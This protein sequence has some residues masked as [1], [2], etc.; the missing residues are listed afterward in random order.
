MCVCGKYQDISQAPYSPP[1]G[2]LVEVAFSPSPPTLALT[3][4][5]T[6]ACSQGGIGPIATAI[7]AA[8]AAIS[9][10]L[11]RL[12]SRSLPMVCE[13]RECVPQEHP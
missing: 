12:L 2:S 8:A 11:P 5:V 13:C 10:T 4:T 6:V 1:V 3:P 9:V 7:A